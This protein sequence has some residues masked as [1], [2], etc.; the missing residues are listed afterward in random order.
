MLYLWRDLSG[1]HLCIHTLY[2]STGSWWRWASLPSLPALDEWCS[3]AAANFFRPSGYFRSLCT[4]A[5]SLCCVLNASYAWPVTIK[6]SI[7][8]VWGPW[9][10]LQLSTSLGRCNIV[11][12]LLNLFYFKRIF[13]VSSELHYIWG[14]QLLLRPTFGLSDLVFIY[15]RNC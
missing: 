14:K 1:H 13:F 2:L 12:E 10:S 15:W 8:S 3:F 9:M 5:E 11:N 4:Q 6:P 7:F